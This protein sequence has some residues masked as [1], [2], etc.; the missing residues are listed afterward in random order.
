MFT[1]PAP[2]SCEKGKGWKFPMN[3][4]RRRKPPG[5]PTFQASQLAKAPPY[6]EGDEP[7]PTGTEA[8]SPRPAASRLRLLTRHPPGVLPS[9]LP[10]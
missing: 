3:H 2:G 10:A 4:T 1:L 6:Q 7:D 8:P 5:C 9:Q